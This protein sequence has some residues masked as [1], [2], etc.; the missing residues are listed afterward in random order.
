VD[1]HAE[2]GRRDTA[3]PE[4]P[5]CVDLSAAAHE[6]AGL[7]RYAACL[8]EALLAEGTPLTAF[9]NDAKASHL[10]PPLSEVP[11]VTA[12]LA[13]KPWRVRAAL[14]YAGGPSIGALRDVRFFHATEHLLPR[15]PG[16]RTVFTLHDTAYLLFPEY[17]LPRNRIFLRHMMPRFLRQADRVIAVS[18]NTKREALRSYDLEPGKIEVIPEG[19]DERFRPDLDPAEVEEVRRRYALPERFVLSIGTIEPRK[20][21]TTLLE[22]YAV[23][24]ERH[25]DVGLVIAGGKG[26]MVEPFF[27]RLRALGLERDAVLTGYVPD[28][29]VPALLNAAEVFAFPSEF[30]GFG[31]P[32]LEAMACGVPVVSSDAASLPEVVGDAGVQLPPRD[33]RAWVQALDSL[34]GDPSARAGRRAAG[35]ARARGFTWTAA[36]RRTLEVYRAAAQGS[37]RAPGPQARP[38]S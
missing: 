25:P 9:V 21:L 36:A 5:Y 18:E 3:I 12:G 1:P 16:A 31:L 7:G 24:R 28:Q 20:N 6:R 2:P 4:G 26:W 10:R 38:S 13:R 19:V 14:T 23:V 35:L 17:H 30:E 11:T 29:D 15:I 27:E 8:A 33:V 32:P 37:P 34:L 22:A